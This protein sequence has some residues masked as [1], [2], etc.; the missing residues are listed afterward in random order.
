MGFGGVIEY[1]NN[2]IAQITV[3]IKIERKKKSLQ[4]MWGQMRRRTGERWQ[5]GKYLKEIGLK[6]NHNKTAYDDIPSLPFHE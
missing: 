5:V 4:V 1:T 2:K 6:N 3:K